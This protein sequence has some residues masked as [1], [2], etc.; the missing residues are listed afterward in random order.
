[1]CERAG[2]RAGRPDWSG[3]SGFTVFC[4]PLLPPESELELEPD[5]EL[6]IENGN[7]PNGCKSERMGKFG[8]GDFEIL[9]VVG[10]GAF[11]K[12]FQVRNPPPSSQSKPIAVLQARS[13]ASVSNLR[14]FTATPNPARKHC[15]KPPLPH[16]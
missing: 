12:V 8:P 2:G 16:R 13:T 1:M 7:G 6:E 10:Q 3:G 11:G 5:S 14:I 4:P 9:R 15:S